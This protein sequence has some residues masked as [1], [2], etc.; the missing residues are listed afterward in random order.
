[1]ERKIAGLIL[2]AGSSSRLGR[3]KQLL[4]YKDKTLL[5]HTIAVAN[6]A[7][8]IDIYVVVGK[9]NAQ[10]DAE[11]TK[12]IKV[13]NEHWKAGMG[14]SLACGMKALM[15]ESVEYE[16]LVLL[17]SDQPYVNAQLLKALIEAGV[18]GGIV[19]SDYGVGAGP[20]S[21]FDKVYFS[22]LAELRGDVGAR[23]IVKAHKEKVTKIHFP[24]GQFDIDTPEDLKKLQ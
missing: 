12:V 3:P 6:E 7:G 15:Q 9:E 2:A 8:L 5:G 10:I 1:M 20:P 24:K 22:A 4:R 14:S 11:C 23:G 21:Y 17:L 19:V 13:R 16:G 18:A